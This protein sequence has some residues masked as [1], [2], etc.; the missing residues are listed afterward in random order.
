[1]KIWLSKVVSD[2]IEAGADI[3]YLGGYGSFDH[4]AATVVKEQKAF[5]P[6]IKSVLVIPYLDKEWDRDRY[7][8]SIYPGLENVPPW[9]A[10]AFIIF[11][12]SFTH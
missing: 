10:I 2:L 8:N 11:Y 5:H 12:C 9:F 1:V 4:L 3:F 6:E 7:D